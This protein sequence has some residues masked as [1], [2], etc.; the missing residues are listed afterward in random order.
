MTEA[1][2]FETTPGGVLVATPGCVS[3]S[4]PAFWEA[5]ERCESGKVG[6]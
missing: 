6:R 3:K 1:I 2:R 5:I 4:Y